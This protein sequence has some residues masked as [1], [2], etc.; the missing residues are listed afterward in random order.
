MR[1]RERK[2]RQAREGGGRRRGERGVEKD[3]DDEGM[4]RRWKGGREWRG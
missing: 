3:T 2:T 4:R 1:E